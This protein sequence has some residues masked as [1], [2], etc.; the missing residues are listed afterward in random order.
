MGH[1]SLLKRESVEIKD[2]VHYEDVQ[3]VKNNYE[4]YYKKLVNLIIL[5]TFKLINNLYVHLINNLHLLILYVLNLK[6]FCDNLDT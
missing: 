6:H 3:I 5:T 4:V 1:I 2:N